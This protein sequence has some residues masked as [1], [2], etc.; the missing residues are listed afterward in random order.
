MFYTMPLKIASD[1]H[2]IPIECVMLKALV[3]SC[4][5]GVGHSANILV[6]GVHLGSYPSP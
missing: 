5:P 3:L 4:Q 6:G 2:L 1:W